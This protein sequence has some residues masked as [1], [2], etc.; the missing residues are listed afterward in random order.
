MRLVQI[1]Q[2]EWFGKYVVCDDDDSRREKP[3]TTKV[4]S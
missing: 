1:V 2:D 4:A 3:R